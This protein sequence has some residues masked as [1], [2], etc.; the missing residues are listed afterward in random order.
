M[1]TIQLK[2]KN[3]IRGSWNPISILQENITH[4]YLNFVSFRFFF[5]SFFLSFFLPFIFLKKKY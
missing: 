4:V 1:W 3:F 2:E 5:L